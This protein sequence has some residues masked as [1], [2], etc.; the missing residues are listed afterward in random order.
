MKGLESI[1]PE[2]P[3]SRDGQSS[4]DGDLPTFF[5]DDEV[6]V[7]E[8]LRDLIKAYGRETFLRSLKDVL[9]N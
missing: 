8:E 4:L 1:E 7:I 6:I 5:K 9:H 2:V 3:E